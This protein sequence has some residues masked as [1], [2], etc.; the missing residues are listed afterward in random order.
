[1]HLDPSKVLGVVLAHSSAKPTV[2]RH[3]PY[4]LRTCARLILFVPE[5][6]MMGLSHPLV[7]EIEGVRDGGSYSTATNERCYAALKSSRDLHPEFEYVMLFEYDSLCWSPIPEVA[8]PAEGEISAIV[9]PN[10]PVTPIKGRPF[11]APTYLH[12]PQIY[13]RTAISKLLTAMETTVPWDAEW[14]YTDRYLG[15]A[16]HRS[17]VKVKDL[18]RMGLAYS[19]E[20]IS[21]SGPYPKRVEECVEAVKRGAVFTHGVKDEA[22]L[23]RIAPHGGFGLLDPVV[24]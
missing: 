18:R 5:G 15:L 19:Y 14:G 4:W 6:Q 7:K 21:Y 11:I 9:W 12:F 22:T 23:K 17:G 10:E 8:I 1:M 20:N 2:L 3:L 24:S 16:A 13:T